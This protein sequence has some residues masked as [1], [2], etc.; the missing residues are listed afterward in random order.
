MRTSSS[1]S[2]SLRFG[3]CE[4]LSLMVTERR[5]AGYQAFMKVKRVPPLQE[6][7]ASPQPREEP[8]LASRERAGS[9]IA[10]F[11][12]TRMVMIRFELI[13]A[14]VIF[15]GVVVFFGTY[16][17]ALSEDHGKVQADMTSPAATS[18]STTCPFE[19]VIL[20]LAGLRKSKASSGW[21]CT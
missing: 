18:F 6:R 15:A 10:G 12:R 3:G 2:R 14:V 17:P 4:V 5:S 7:G 9:H 16:T 19:R 8:D 13:G 20:T 11:S 21:E 1:N